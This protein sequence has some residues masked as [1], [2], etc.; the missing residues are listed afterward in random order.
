MSGSKII[1]FCYNHGVC[2]TTDDQVRDNVVYDSKREIMN[3]LLK[4][5]S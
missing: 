2:A 3:D 4:S 5:E 1:C